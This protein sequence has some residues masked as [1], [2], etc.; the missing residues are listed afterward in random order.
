MHASVILAHPDPT[1][2]SHA[3][4]SAACEQLISNGYDLN[5]HDLYEEGF[6]PLLS[7]HESR[8]WQSDDALVEQHCHEIA[9]ADAIVL[10]HPNWWGQPPAILKGWVDRVLRPGVAYAWGDHDRGEGIPDGLLRAKAAI[11]FNT[12][13]TPTEREAVVFGNPLDLLWRDCIFG[14]CGVATFNR[15]VFTVMTTSTA[16]QRAAWLQEV[17]ATV[18][19]Y[20]PGT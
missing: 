12:A 13:N 3:I 14:L 6:N 19:T 10:I 18:T 5:V 8:V 7:A 2:F 15:R 11:V 9:H 4:A 20:F 1:S 16:D 17:R